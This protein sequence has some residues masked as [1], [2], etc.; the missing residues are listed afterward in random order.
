MGRQILK[1]TLADPPIGRQ[2]SKTTL[3]DP[4]IGCQIL[5]TTLA[6][7]LIGRQILKT[8]LADPPIGLL[9]RALSHLAYWQCSIPW[10]LLRSTDLSLFIVIIK[11]VVART[12]RR[13]GFSCNCASGAPEAA[14]HSCNKCS[15]TPEAILHRCNKCSG[16]PEHVLHPCS[17]FS[18]DRYCILQC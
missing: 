1:T 13:L 6:D 17:N 7:P 12:A 10:S 16:A 11:L 3:A 18:S 2:I 5:K 8:T 4:P 15:G 14:L 9:H